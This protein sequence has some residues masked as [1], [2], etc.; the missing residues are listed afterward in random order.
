MD[1]TVESVQSQ[2]NQVL[3][4]TAGRMQLM[5]QQ[6]GEKDTE[7][8]RLQQA[9]AVAM[10][11]AAVRFGLVFSLIFIGFALGFRRFS[12]KTRRISGASCGSR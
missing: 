2:M 12:T 5:Q 11:A 1:T 7:I 4:G 10:E 6:L 8:A 9:V 3:E